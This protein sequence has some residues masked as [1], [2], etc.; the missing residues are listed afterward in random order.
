M[1]R[2]NWTYGS[3]GSILWLKGP[4][5]MIAQSPT[6][7]FAPQSPVATATATTRRGLLGSLA[8]FI[9]RVAQTEA[10]ASTESQSYWTS[11]ARGQ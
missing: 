4:T 5:K 9:E 6:V 8:A 2:S 7:R 1:K 10:S 11:V 3:A